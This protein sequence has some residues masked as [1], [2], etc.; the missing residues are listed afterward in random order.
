MTSGSSILTNSW[1][2][3]EKLRQ[4]KMSSRYVLEDT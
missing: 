4:W 3:N 2:V 1:D